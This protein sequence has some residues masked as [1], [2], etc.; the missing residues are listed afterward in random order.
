MKKI[1]YVEDNIDNQ[2]LIGYYVKSEPYE[3]T[4]A[5]TG[6]EAIALI[7]QKE[8]DFFLVDLNLSDDVSGT[9]VIKA[10]RNTE[11]N[12][13]KPVAILTAFTQKD[14]ESN[15]EEVQADCVITKPVKKAALLD[16]L[17]DMLGK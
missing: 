11:H 16:I 8:F 5:S 4:F 14:I 15:N 7:E 6:Q 1:L 9:D 13:Q 17:S 10:I 12:Q 3:L 2:F